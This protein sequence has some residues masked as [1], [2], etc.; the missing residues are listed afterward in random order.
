[1]VKRFIGFRLRKGLD[2]DVAEAIKDLDGATISDLARTGMRMALSIKTQKQL[3]VR[4]VPVSAPKL[5][6]KGGAK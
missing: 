4:E 1:M 5:F 3:T 2:E 6:F